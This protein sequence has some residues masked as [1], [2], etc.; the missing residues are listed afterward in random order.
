MERLRQQEE[1][2]VQNTGEASGSEPEL[3]SIVIL[4][5]AIKVVKTAQGEDRGIRK[6]G[7]RTNLESSE[8][9][10]RTRNQ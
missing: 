2:W 1:L 7:L 10:W 9:S 6:S 8:I 5:K 3:L 4:K